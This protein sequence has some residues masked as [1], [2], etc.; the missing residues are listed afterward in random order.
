MSR[1][2]LDFIERSSWREDDRR[3]YARDFNLYIRCRGAPSGRIEPPRPAAGRRVED[4]TVGDS[5]AHMPASPYRIH[6]AHTR[7]IDEGY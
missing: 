2:A 7:Q 3:A 1:E 6:L 4:G 5:D